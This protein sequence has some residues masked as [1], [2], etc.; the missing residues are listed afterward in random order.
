MKREG[1]DFK[2]FYRRKLNNKEKK[3]Y[4]DYKMF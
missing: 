1:N 4:A 3:I 2:L